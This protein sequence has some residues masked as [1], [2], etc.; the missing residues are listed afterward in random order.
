[1]TPPASL[2]IVLVDDHKALR[3]LLRGFLESHPAMT[4]AGEAGDP[5]EAVQKA[6][7]LRPDVVVVDMHL[8][9]A[10]GRYD[11]NA[12]IEAVRDI[13][14]RCPGTGILVTTGLEQGV[15][16]LSVALAAGARGFVTKYAE[17]HVMLA[18]IEGVA[19]GEL[20]VIVPREFA[21][22]MRRAIG[23]TSPNADALT[24]REREILDCFCKGMVDGQIAR[25][26]S[27]SP[28]TVANYFTSIQGKL[29][30]SDRVSLLRKAQDRGWC[31]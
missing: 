12:G 31:D 11:V 4:V 29:G 25:R 28:H 15:E 27:I 17:P 21:D 7:E 9:T 1:M 20:W 16:K 22:D 2:R 8:P 6:E 18:A 24:R 13:A 26:L 19:R 5:V 14:A 30:A 23:R 10:A 3:S